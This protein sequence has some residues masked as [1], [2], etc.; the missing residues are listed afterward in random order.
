MTATA[1]HRPADERAVDATVGAAGVVVIVVGVATITGP[2]IT[3]VTSIDAALA[4][5]MDENIVLNAARMLLKL[6][7]PIGFPRPSF[8]VGNAPVAFCN[9]GALNF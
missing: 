4:G 5:R 7:L 6:K 3:G 8:L 9:C 2:A 1:A